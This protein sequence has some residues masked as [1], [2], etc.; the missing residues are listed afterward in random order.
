MCDG[1]VSERLPAD[2][3]W[4]SRAVRE[5][6]YVVL[7]LLQEI[8]DAIRQVL[9]G[10]NQAEGCS[11]RLGNLQKV[12]PPKGS[13]DIVQCFEVLHELSGERSIGRRR[14]TLLQAAPLSEASLDQLAR[15]FLNDVERG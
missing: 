8:D 9:G 13:F 3:P 1:S 4:A 11:A 5:V 6:A 12:L 15:D 14:A 2:P 10:S 7:I